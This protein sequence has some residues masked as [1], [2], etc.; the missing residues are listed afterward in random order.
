LDL[1]SLKFQRQPEGHLKR[2]VSEKSE[3]RS[4]RMDLSIRL[5]DGPIS[6][7]YSWLA[8]GS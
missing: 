5:V 1:I 2:Q 3:V 4:Y 8:P 6:H 7:S